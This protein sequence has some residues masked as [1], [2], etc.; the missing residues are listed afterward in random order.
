MIDDVNSPVKLS[1]LAQ[2]RSTELRPLPLT[3]R[4]G[5]VAAFSRLDAYP[6]AEAASGF[7]LTAAA[8][9]APVRE[10]RRQS[11]SSRAVIRPPTSQP[12]RAGTDL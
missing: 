1:H 10:L 9:L 11:L 7:R 12:L 3:R 2:Q 6:L 4:Q 8:G 5:S